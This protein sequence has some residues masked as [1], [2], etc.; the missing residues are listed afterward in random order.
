MRSISRWA[1]H[2]IAAARTIILFSHII[3]IFLAGYIGTHVARMPAKVFYASAFA[4]IIAAIIYPGRSLKT[5]LGKNFFVFRKTGEFVVA[6]GLFLL[7]CFFVNHNLRLPSFQNRV[8]GF[9]A[10]TTPPAINPA[11]AQ[12]LE[13]L[14][15]RDKSTL[16]KQEKRM[17][18]KEFKTQLHA[19]T[20]A[21]R[22]HD[23]NE[24][25]HAVEI[26]VT[27]IV[28]LGLLFLLTMLACSISC[29][30]AE[31]LAVIVLIAGIGVLTF[32]TIKVINGITKKH[33]AKEQEKNLQ[34]ESGN[35]TGNNLSFIRVR[36]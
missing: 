17:L 21:H 12:I 9:T 11:A 35:L 20:K 33:K 34:G 24:E 27:I 8:Y 6:T 28:A 15:Y 1:E 16:T 10:Q 30:G 31:A 36:P 23:R 29:A 32:A 14:K 5:L 3:L 19:Y 13:S 4:V 22:A 7:T 25:S 26:I 2:H 18:K